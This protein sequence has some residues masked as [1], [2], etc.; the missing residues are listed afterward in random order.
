[1]VAL[2]G[3]WAWVSTM[4]PSLS[5]LPPI[6]PPSGLSLQQSSLDLSLR[7][8]RVRKQKLPAFLKG[9]LEA[10][11]ITST[12]VHCSQQAQVNPRFEGW[13]SRFPLF[14]ET[15]GHTGKE[16]LV[17]ALRESRPLSCFW[18]RK[19]RRKTSQLLLLFVIAISIFLSSCPPKSAS[20]C[21][22]HMS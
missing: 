17:A 7:V 2:G 6:P 22:R 8:P 10:R 5:Y 21:G 16:G 20:P 18:G 14:V 3:V 4:A 1:M 9:R 12:I 15:D 11:S 13:K 19:G